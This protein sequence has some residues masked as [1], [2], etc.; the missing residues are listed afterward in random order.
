[1]RIRRRVWPR[2]LIAL[3]VVVALAGG[4]VLQW[5]WVRSRAGDAADQIARWS[6]RLRDTAATLPE[7]EVEARTVAGD[8]TSVLIVIG[9][10]F[11]DAAFALISAAPA[12]DPSLVIFPQ[13]MLVS[14]PGYGEFR[15][16]DALVFEGPDLVAL[17]VTNQFGI[18][19]DRIVAVPAGGIAAA[20]DGPVPVDL[21]APMF[22]ETD[23][24]I[25]R[26]LDAGVS[27]VPSDLLET[28]L[29][30]QGEGDPFEWLQRQA[31][32]WRSILAAVAERP[33]I[34][35]ALLSESAGSI[36]ADLLVTV[37]G[38]DEAV[39]VTIPVER[40]ESRS[41]ETLAPV[42]DRVDGFVAERLGH[43]V[44][45]TGVRPRI[46]ILNGNGK[47]GT[48]RG[49]A[50]VL[51]R[52]GFRL[53]RTDNADRFDYRETLVIGQGRQNE[54]AA[55]QVAAALGRGSLQL[56]VRAPSAVVDVSIIVG[57]DIPAEEG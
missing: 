52:L 9:S 49:V 6:T 22:Q 20:I 35:D 1:M 14:V 8:S 37:A 18:R 48:T 56:E 51:V 31:T 17:S 19:I 12:G 34:A 13:S 29:V 15:L 4:A 39:L 43:L 47:V 40:A 3:A 53:I 38:R 42:T 23:G 57:D 25:R 5:E 10:G 16:V 27:E 30:T 55:R 2:V 21:A 11:D 46:E 32:V 45:W 54:T 28:L 24:T 26:V 7:A 44:I 41:P 33:A 36:A 50:T